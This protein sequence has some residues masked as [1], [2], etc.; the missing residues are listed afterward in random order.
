[1]QLMIL[2]IFFEWCYL[3]ILI[4]SVDSSEP[5][6]AQT[7]SYGPDPSVSLQCIVL[8]SVSEELSED[9]NMANICEA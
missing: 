4:M 1:M 3:M 9:A 7:L 2:E 6:Q 8:I 5:A